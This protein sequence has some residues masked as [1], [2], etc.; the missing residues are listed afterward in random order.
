MKLENLT[1]T[2]MVEGQ[3]VMIIL[4]DDQKQLL[5]QLIM[6]TALDRKIKVAKLDPTKY[7]LDKVEFDKS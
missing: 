2:A 6:S 3:P 1:V 7:F 5:P 4:N